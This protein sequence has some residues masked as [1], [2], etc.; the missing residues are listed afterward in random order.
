MATAEA[1]LGGE[2]DARKSEGSA[3]EVAGGLDE[4]EEDL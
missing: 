2:R 4:T 3:R 1:L